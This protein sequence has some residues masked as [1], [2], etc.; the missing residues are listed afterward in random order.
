MPTVASATPVKKPAPLVSAVKL[1]DEFL[2][3]AFNEK[4]SDVHIEPW[5]T[6]CRVRIRVDGVLVGIAQY[7]KSIHEEVVAR[8]KVLASLRTDVRSLPQDGRFKF[9]IQAISVNVR[10]S[11]TPSFY[12]EKIVLRLL[13]VSVNPHTLEHLGFCNSDIEAMSQA[14]SVFH[15]MVLVSGP[16]GSGKTTTL[17]TLLHKISS[18]EISV[19]TLEDPIEYSIPGITQIPIHTGGQMTFANVLRATVRQDPDVL[20]VGEIRDSATAE[21]STHIALTGHLLLSTVHTNDA[22]TTIPRLIDMGIEP[23]LI[24]STLRAVVS[25]RLVRKICSSCKQ[26]SKITQSEAEYLKRSGA[27]DPENFKSIR[28]R[29]CDLCKNTGYAGRTVIAEVL[30]ITD[31]I[32]T[33]IMQKATPEEIRNVAIAQGMTPLLQD[34]VRKIRFGITTFE[35]VVSI[36]Q[37]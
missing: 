37:N 10:I 19:V 16:T 24:A 8:L 29:G 9:N 3:R 18:P 12:G 23:F 1:V 36:C 2:T 25:Q 26:E 33:L 31:Q 32:R 21:L 30:P 35:E 34:A 6:D 22:V 11:I 7:Q 20:M 28:G 27:I 13:P 17:Y 4:A 15:G 5:E 14:L